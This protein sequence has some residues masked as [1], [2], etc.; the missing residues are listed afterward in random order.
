[1]LTFRDEIQSVYRPIFDQILA[2]AK[3]QILEVE[4][5]CKA[6]MKVSRQE[7]DFLIH[8]DHT[9]SRWPWLESISSRFP[10]IEI[11]DFN[12]NKTADIGVT[13]VVLPKLIFRRYT[14]IVRG[15][16]LYKMGLN[17]V[18]ERLMRRNY[19]VYGDII[20][21]PGH[22]PKDRKYVDLA[23]VD[24]CRGTILWYAYKVIPLNAHF[25]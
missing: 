24:R 3:A 21:N 23:G 8:I 2:L 11:T 15:A 22:H 1:M 18:K 19:G 6:K 20:F 17:I 25:R 7:F 4:N 16:V 10:Q 9:A 13:I 5:K 14:S 12:S